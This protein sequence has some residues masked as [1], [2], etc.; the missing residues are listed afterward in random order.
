MN[1][2]RRAYAKIKTTMNVSRIRRLIHEAGWVVLGQVVNIAGLLVLVRV[3]TE[4]LKPDQYGHLALG[5]TAAGL[6]NQVVMGGIVA[7]IGRYYSI[8]V[9]SGGW[10]SYVHASRRLLICAAAAVLLIA[11]LLAGGLVLWGLFPWINLLIVTLFFSILSGCN[12]SLSG[13]QNAARDR[14]VVAFHSGLEVWL[15]ILVAIAAMHYSGGSAFTVMSAY[16]LSLA[17]VVGSQFVFLRRIINRQPVYVVN[18]EDWTKRMWAYALPFSTFGVFTWMHQISDKWALQAFTSAQEIGLFAVAFQLG[19]APIGLVTGMAMNF[20]G[21]II[22]QRSGRAMDGERNS[23][24][25]R[26]AWQ[27]ATL[28]LVLAVGGFVSTL[29]THQ[30]IFLLLVAENYRSVSYL[31]PWLVLAGGI[32]SSGE[33]LA[34]KLMSEMRPSSM[35]RVK[36]STAFIGV[37]LNISGAVLFGLQ[38]VVAALVLFSGIYL[39]CMAKLAR[40]PPSTD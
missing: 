40:H 9:E 23:S 13:I 27:F 12:A 36:I 7:S 18:G 24:V 1:Y 16:V 17:A 35:A 22:Y 6:V 14:R 39:S 38:G 28:G 33:M 37:L 32:F 15:R 2:T 8:A 19:Y 11:L 25:H 20:L 4:H 31:L 29:L 10:V 5:L 3:L 26:V 34:L 21:P 30:W